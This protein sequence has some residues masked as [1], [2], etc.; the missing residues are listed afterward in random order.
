VT[1]VICTKLKIPY[2]REAVGGVHKL[3][4]ATNPI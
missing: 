4:K 2:F 1:S 3:H